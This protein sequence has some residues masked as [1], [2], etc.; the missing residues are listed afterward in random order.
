MARKPGA[1]A[2]T[3]PAPLD[4]AVLHI[5]YGPLWDCEY[6]ALPWPCPTYREAGTTAQRL[7]ALIYMA[8]RALRDLR[9]LPPF[10]VVRR[11]LFPVALSDTELRRITLDL[12]RSRTPVPDPPRT[13]HVP[14]RPLWQC[15]ACRE[16]WPCEPARRSLVHE[17]ADARP[18]LLVHLG[19]MLAH[20]GDQM[21]Q[22]GQRPSSDE[23]DRRFLAWARTRPESAET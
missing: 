15:A 20:A 18:A 7:G 17:F 19:A 21:Y 8:H 1:I 11:F 22:I 10:E 14:M 16:P 13:A 12:L 6:C 23:L 2:V 3:T 5:G 9:H 4:G